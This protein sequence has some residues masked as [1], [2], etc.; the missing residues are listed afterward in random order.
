MD[1]RG[2]KQPRKQKRNRRNRIKESPWGVPTVVKWTEGRCCLCSSS[3]HFRG[4]GSIPSL[5]WVKDLV[6]P[7]LWHRSQLWLRFDPYPGNFHMLQVENNNNDNDNNN[8]L[9]SQCFEIPEFKFITCKS[10]VVLIHFFF[11]L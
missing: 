11:S 8:H 3:S 2:Q 5:E 6:F 7:Q 10:P 4:I 9:R 1:E